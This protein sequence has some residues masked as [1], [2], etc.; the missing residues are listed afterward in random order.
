LIS[1][2]NTKG[3]NDTFNTKRVKLKDDV[4]GFWSNKSL[5]FEKSGISY[6]ITYMNDNI[7]DEQRKKDLIEM[8]NQMIEK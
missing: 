2:W 4:E 5:F 3:T 6:T 7:S 8:A 1:V